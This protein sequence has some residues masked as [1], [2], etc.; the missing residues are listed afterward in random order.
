VRIRKG[1]EWKTTFSTH[2]NHFQYVVMPF[3]LT[4][5]LA[6][7][8]HLMNDVF[9]EYLDDFTVYYINDILIFSKNMEDYKHHV[10]LV[11]KKLWEAKLYAKLKKCNFHQS[12]VE[13]LGYTI[14]GKAFAWIYQRFRPL[15]TRLLYVLFEM[16][17]VFL[18]LLT[19][20]DVS[21]LIILE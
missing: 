10:H 14:F 15:W 13:F 7:F 5:A 8:Q 1:V 4:N 6:I 21:L 17:N 19:F 9:Y 2:Y 18:D 12:K 11:L 3:G 16:S 20:I